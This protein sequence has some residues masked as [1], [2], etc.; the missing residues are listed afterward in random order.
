[1]TQFTKA[2]AYLDSFSS[3]KGLL[4]WNSH[5]S[6]PQQLLREVGNVTACNGDVLYAAA[7]HIAF[8]LQHK[9]NKENHHYLT[10]PANITNQCHYHTLPREFMLSLN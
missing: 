8:C 9:Y 4:R 6:L 1:M 10:F 5:L 2:D 7:N 3:L